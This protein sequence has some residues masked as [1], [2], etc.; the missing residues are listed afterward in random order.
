[1]ISVNHKDISAIGIAQ[2]A[3][4]IVCI[5]SRIVWQSVRSCF[6][7]GYWINDKPWSNTDGWMN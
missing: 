5:A 1:M 2:K 6:G 4:N 7:K 3:I